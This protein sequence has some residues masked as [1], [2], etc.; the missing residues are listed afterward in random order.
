MIKSLRLETHHRERYLLL[1]TVTPTDT[2]T[3]VIAIIEDE[4]GSVL[5][6]QLYY[7]EEELSG[8]QS[9]R[10]DTVLVVKECYVKVMA[11]GDYGIRVDHLSDPPAP[12]PLPPLVYPRV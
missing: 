10:E 7:Q 11:N 3:A 9:L 5:M 2:M 8:A 4:D 6:L 12:Y 1:R